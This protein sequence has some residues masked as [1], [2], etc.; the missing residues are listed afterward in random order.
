MHIGSFTHPRW[1]LLWLA[2]LFGGMLL[3]AFV[4]ARM[5]SAAD[6]GIT[7]DPATD[8]AVT[9]GVDASYTVV[10]TGDTAP[11]GN[12]TV[13]IESSNTDV[14]VDTDPDT[15]DSQTTLTFTADNYKMAQTVAVT[16]EDDDTI[17]EIARLTH[18][19]TSSDDAFNGIADAV[20]RV[21][22]TDDDV[23]GVKLSSG[24]GDDAFDPGTK[25]FEVDE[26]DISVDLDSY[27][28]VL[29]AAPAADVMVTISSD[30]DDVTFTGANDDGDLVLTFTDQNWSQ[31]QTVQAAV[32]A[33][34]TTENESVTLTHKITSADSGYNALADQTVMVEI[35][36]DD[37]ADLG[38]HRRSKRR[39]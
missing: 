37:P 24:T 38:V 3:L 12:V 1:P 28:V 31:E 29:D 36:D 27:T 23:A 14:V 5:V 26:I 22:V 18:E 39:A 13:E 6:E 20:L 15:A 7:L 16:A 19:V 9:E 21:V 32:A 10:L 33:D 8:L 35:T 30:N 34:D 2:I 25:A 4:F 11:T 17:N